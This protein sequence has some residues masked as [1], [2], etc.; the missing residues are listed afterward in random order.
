MRISL[1]A[2]LAFLCGFAA[3]VVVVQHRV[4][5]LGA[6]HLDGTHSPHHLRAKPQR[7][8]ARGA[9][10][11]RRP[12][13]INYAPSDRRRRAPRRRR[14]APR[15]PRKSAARPSASRPSAAP[16][17]RSRPR[18]RPSRG[19]QRRGRREA[20]AP[21]RRTRSAPTRDRRG[22]PEAAARLARGQ[23]E[24][25]RQKPKL[26][27]DD[28]PTASEVVYWSNTLATPATLPPPRQD[29]Y[30][31]FEYDAGGWNNIRMGLEC[32]VV[33]GHVL[34]RTVVLPPPQPGL[35]LDREQLPST[36]RFWFCRFPQCHITGK[37][38]WLAHAVH[39]P[40]S[41]AKDQGRADHGQGPLDLEGRLTSCGR[42]LATRRAALRHLLC[43][44]ERC[45]RVMEEHELSAGPEGRQAR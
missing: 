9:A 13:S 38:F 26:M 42:D 11:A 34:R 10:A 35:Y 2:V 41:R 31:T 40:V 12:C 27:C 45:S 39:G 32:L 36:A 28:V 5:A 20:G 33:L 1:P 15:R 30:L 29:K 21:A 16:R 7:A 8:A 4:P 3:T 37:S 22:A 18:A 17:P 19:K 25:R 43:A 6:L 23:E 24:T 14:R 44:R